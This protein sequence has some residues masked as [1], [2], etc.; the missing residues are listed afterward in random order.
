MGYPDEEHC[1]IRSTGVLRLSSYAAAFLLLLSMSAC[2]N[3]QPS[4]SPPPPPAT[5]PADALLSGTYVFGVSGC[6]NSIVLGGQVTADGQGNITAGSLTSNS[7]VT[8][9]ATSGATLTGSYTMT[10]DGRGQASLTPTPAIFDLNSAIITLNFVLISKTHGYVVEFDN[11]G[12]GSGTLDLQ[13]PTSQSNLA[14]S[15]VVS[16]V[17]EYMK[18]ANSLI[19]AGAFTLDASGNITAGI[20]DGVGTPSFIVITYLAQPLSGSLL[21]GSGNS[22]GKAGFQTTFLGTAPLPFDVY[23]IDATHLILIGTDL[24]FFGEAFRQ[25]TALPSGSQVFSMAGEDA[26]GGGGTE[27]GGLMTFDGTG[28]VTGGLEDLND[29]GNIDLSM[30]FAGSYSA[31]DSNGRA[32]MTLIG[33]NPQLQSIGSNTT[34]QFVLYPSSGGL[35][36]LEIDG[37]AGLMGAAFVQTNPSLPTSQPFG[38]SLSGWNDSGDFSDTAQFTTGS[39]GTGFSGLIDSNTFGRSDGP[40]TQTSGQT[41]TGTYSLDSATGRG[42]ISSNSS[43][44]LEFYLIDDTSAVFIGISGEQQAQGSFAAQTLSGTKSSMFAVP[45]FSVARM[46]ASQSAGFRG[47]SRRKTP[48]LP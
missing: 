25:G 21:V 1:S 36:I 20:Q 13:A 4:S 45:R 38:M 44:D 15:Y 33:F 32:T 31:L 41:F 23:P 12:C 22:P 5:D 19:I 46:P 8:G 17:G 34:T 10:S 11:N 39:S 48:S 7:I 30:P 28:N 24:V 2:G 29:S 18:N 40:W 16:L 3:S 42:S 6:I 26:S 9:V 35:V 14:G 27:V 37:I 47:A 43:P